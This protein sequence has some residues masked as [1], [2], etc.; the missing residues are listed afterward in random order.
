MY[1]CMFGCMLCGRSKI[2]NAATLAWNY[3]GYKNEKISNNDEI[4]QITKVPNSNSIISRSTK[5]NGLTDIYDLNGESIGQEKYYYD[6][7]KIEKSN[8]SFSG[9]RN[10][11]PKFM[12]SVVNDVELRVYERGLCQNLNFDDRR[13]K[14]WSPNVAAHG[15]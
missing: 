3:Y 1:V 6:E 9:S 8:Y 5:M 14:F 15:K 10:W 4:S 11:T 13:H 12:T 7:L 2:K